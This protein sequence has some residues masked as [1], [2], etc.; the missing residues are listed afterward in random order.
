MMISTKFQR[1][2]AHAIA[3]AII[4]FLSGSS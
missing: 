1:R 3:A 2:A 4:T